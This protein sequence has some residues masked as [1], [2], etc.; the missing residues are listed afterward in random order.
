M[1]ITTVAP[2]RRDAIALGL[3]QYCN[4]VP[5]KN[6]N[7]APRLVSSSRC[8]CDK[9]SSMATSRTR[10][11]R[12][13]NP[14]RSAAHAKKWKENHLE[15]YREIQRANYQ[16]N[17]GAIQGRNALYRL[18]MA[19]VLR[20]SRMTYYRNNRAA[21]YAL[22][23]KRKAAKRRAV[24]TW[25]GELDVFVNQEANRLAALRTAVTGYAW[26]VDHMLP[27]QCPTVSGLHVWNNLQVIPALINTVKKNRMILT[28]PG[29][30]LRSDAGT[31]RQRSTGSKT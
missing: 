2:K 22:T 18:K 31:L 10:D 3:K 12:H 17:I 4:G 7:V 15:Q 9:C 13:A 5:C 21:H 23:Q 24:P 20:T 11:W 14:A 6:G 19:S 25:Y 1:Q 30:W 28:E 8:M 27:L 16:A 29:E 26:H